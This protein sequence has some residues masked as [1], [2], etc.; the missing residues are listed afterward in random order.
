V[1]E[2][3]VLMG[4][5]GRPHGVRG[6]A[7]VRSYTAEPADLPG[8]GP[9]SD[10]RGRRFSLRWVSEGVAAITEM[11]DGKKVPVAN[12]DAA[13]R[14][15]NVRL[16]VDRAQLPAAGEEEFYLIDLVGLQAVGPDGAALG[17][18][19]AVH[20]YG[21]GTSLEIGSLLVP[22][23]RACVPQVDIA[24]GRLVVVPPAEVSVAPDAEAAP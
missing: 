20:D 14:L 13:E 12:R 11:V 23:T 7:H 22:F 8:Y 21:A 2:D 24:G 19:Q 17:T 1:P 5:I 10:E 9:F 16:Y 3:R 4:V 18:V 6:L 15:V